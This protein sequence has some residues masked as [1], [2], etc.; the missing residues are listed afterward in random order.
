[1]PDTVLKTAQ[2]KMDKGIDHLHHQFSGVRTGRANPNI[3]HRIMVPYYGAPTPI[4]Q[5]AS[6]AATDAQTLTVTP[7]DKNVLVDLE[8]SIMEANL[9]FNPTN[10]GN[11]VR[12]AVP[13]LTEERRKEYVKLVKA[14][15]EE[16][17]VAIRNARRDAMSAAKKLEISEGEIAVLEEKIQKLTDSYITKIDSEL[18]AKETDIMTV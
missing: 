16:S 13:A 7:Y 3:L 5:V 9:G 10:D 12:I 6:I 8:K 18:K 2:E 15:A 4:L 11:V 17:K 1:M 14:H